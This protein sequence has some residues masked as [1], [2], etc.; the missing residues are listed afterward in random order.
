VPAIEPYSHAPASCHAYDPRAPA[1]AGKLAELIGGACPQ[2][3]VEHI[4]S[5]AVPGCAGKGVIDLAVLY[6][7]GLLAAARQA[8]DALGFQRQTT[9]DPFPE[10]RPMR[11][12]AVRHDGTLFRVHAHVLA[13]DSPEVEVL[14]AFRDRLRADAAFRADYEARKRAILGEGVTDPVDYC[15]A[16]G[17]FIRGALATSPTRSER[18]P[19]T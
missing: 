9:R 1:V 14:R 2:L 19:G 7:P 15:E 18:C 5:T 11:V 4:G 17:P 10:D 16:K 8:L 12:G 6:P 13:A 3:V